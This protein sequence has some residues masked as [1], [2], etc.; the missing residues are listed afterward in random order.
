[1]ALIQCEKHGHYYDDANHASCP[2]CG[3]D[4]FNIAD[5]ANAAGPKTSTRSGE[6][7]TVDHP[8]SIQ[9][10][11]QQ[12]RSETTT[13]K[14]TGT[15]LIQCDRFGHWYDPELHMFCPL[16]GIPGIDFSTDDPTQGVVERTVENP[17]RRVRSVT[18]RIVQCPSERHY[19]DSARTEQC[20]FCAVLDAAGAS[21]AA[22]NSV[23]EQS[24]PPHFF[25]HKKSRRCPSCFSDPSSTDQAGCD[26]CGWQPDQESTPQALPMGTLLQDRYRVGGCLMRDSFEMRYRCWDDQQD[27]HLTLREF[28]RGDSAV[29]AAD[30][31]AVEPKPGCQNTFWPA[32][33]AWWQLAQEADALA[34]HELIFVPNGWFLANGTGYLL[35][36]C[37]SGETLQDFLARQADGRVPYAQARSLL[38]P[39][40]EAVTALH[41]A[42]WLRRLIT[43]YTLWLADGLT[44]GL[45]L[46]QGLVRMP[47]DG[48]ADEL[49]ELILVPGYSPFEQYISTGSL[50]PWTDV[51][52]LAATL[53]RCITGETPMDALERMDEDELAPPSRL[54]VEIPHEAESA[55]MRALALRIADRTPDVPTFMRELGPTALQG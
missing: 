10:A 42:G 44:V 48:R 7:R 43:P 46:D 50:G 24:A 38:N 34:V 5:D 2:Y 4:V 40:M 39:I 26:V 27:R 33:Q 1:M 16:C 41:E 19:F 36:G 18:Q 14:D 6:R 23:A 32:L 29:R 9:M 30:R 15:G 47:T 3:V 53:Y 54:N 25:D 31:L 20:P 45:G 12:P 13:G 11:A 28:F 21:E 51:Y 55:L 17:H 52:A 35:E 49:F 37:I 22:S 8:A